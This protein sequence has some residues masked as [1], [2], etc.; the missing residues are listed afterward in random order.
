MFASGRVLADFGWIGPNGRTGIR[1]FGRF[2][3]KRK[4]DPAWTNY[5]HLC[6][7][8]IVGPPANKPRVPDVPASADIAPKLSSRSVIITGLEVINTYIRTPSSPSPFKRLPLSM[9]VAVMRENTLGGTSRRLP[10]VDQF[11]PCTPWEVA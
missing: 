7:P 9:L 1:V 10:L 2:A 6:I 5:F 3:R 8:V 4:G 11:T